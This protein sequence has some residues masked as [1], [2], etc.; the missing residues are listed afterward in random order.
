[1]TRLITPELTEDPGP[2]IKHAGSP[3]F[4]RTS[5][6]ATVSIFLEPVAATHKTPFARVLFAGNGLMRSVNE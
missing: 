5:L 4:R 1:M 2:R 3:A 6:A